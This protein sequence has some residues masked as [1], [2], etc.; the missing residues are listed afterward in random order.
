MTIAK[1]V[2]TWVVRG[3]CVVPGRTR[4]FALVTRERLGGWNAIDTRQGR[5]VERGHELEGASVSGRVL[6]FKGVKS[7]AGWSAMLHQLRLNGHAPAA[8]LFQS[9]SASAALGAVVAR[10]PSMTGFDRDLTQLLDTGDDVEV[11]ATE[12]WISIVKAGAQAIQPCE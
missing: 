2:P 1:P 12:G 4:A 5:I 9:M 7:S 10:A 6:V 3:R 8:L 11:D